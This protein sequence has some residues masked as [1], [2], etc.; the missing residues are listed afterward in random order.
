MA[1]QGHKIHKRLATASSSKTWLFLAIA[2]AFS[3]IQEASFGGG[4]EEGTEVEAEGQL[5]QKLT[6]S[7]WESQHRSAE[8][9]T[10]GPL[11]LDEE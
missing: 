1:S 6:A 5:A 8:L 10:H 9:L 2:H 11:H 3:V 4:V 7:W